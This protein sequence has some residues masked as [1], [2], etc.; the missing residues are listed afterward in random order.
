MKFGS[1]EISGAK[2]EQIMTNPSKHPPPKLVG[3]RRKYQN[4]V[5]TLRCARVLFLN[6]P[7]SVITTSVLSSVF[8]DR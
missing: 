4:I 3:Y 1:P 8:V 6:A 2:I 5:L 7:L